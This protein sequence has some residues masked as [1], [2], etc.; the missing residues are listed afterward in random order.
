MFSIKKCLLFSLI[1]FLTINCVAAQENITENLMS[2]NSVYYVSNDGNDLNDGLSINSSFQ[3]IQKALDS[4]NSG[5]TIYLSEGVYKGINN[6]N[7]T[8]DS[9]INII[10]VSPD[11][12]IIDGESINTVFT[13]SEN[14]NVVLKNLSIINARGSFNSYYLP[15][16]ANPS[17]TF[18]EMCGSFTGGAIYNNG[19]L[20][21]ENCIFENN[22][23]WN[24]S[25]E[26]PANAFSKCYGGAIFNNNTLYVYDSVFTN[27]HAGS[28]HQ[29]QAQGGAIFTTGAMQINN[30][31]FDSNTLYANMLRVS[32]QD[33]YAYQ[34][35]AA[36]SGITDFVELNNC[37][38]KNH[39]LDVFEEYMTTKYFAERNYNFD[40]GS[41][42]GAVYY[43]GDNWK[44]NN[45]SF[46]NNSADWGGAVSFRG[47]NIEFDGCSFSNNSASAGCGIFLMDYDL[48]QQYGYIYDGNK[49]DYSNILI[50]NTEFLDNF[51]KSYIYDQRIGTM[52]IGASSCFIKADNVKI[53]NSVFHDRSVLK[54]L[55]FIVPDPKSFWLPTQNIKYSG[56]LVHI[57]GK[58]SLISNSVFEEGYSPLGGAIQDYGFDKKI[59]NC[60]FLDNYAY[61]GGAI[62]HSMGD[63]SVENCNFINNAAYNHG[64]SVYSI[65]SYSARDYSQLIS[66]YVNSSFINGNASYGGAIF[67]TGDNI[68]F[69]D[70]IFINHTAMYGGAIYVLGFN[71]QIYGSDFINATAV[72]KDYSDGGAIYISGDNFLF[73][74]CE[75]INASCGNMGGSIY[76]ISNNI[77]GYNS[78]FI[79]SSAFKGGSIYISGNKGRIQ[80][81]NFKNT[82]ATL[83]GCIYNMADEIIISY[84]NIDST[85]AE[86]AAGAIY[87]EGN[88]IVLYGNNITNSKAGTL[89]NCTYT[90]AS[91]SYLVVSF[92]NNETVEIEKN[93]RKSISAD[94][95]DNLGNPITG[96]YITFILIDSNGD[97]LV[98]GEYEVI[99]GKA[100]VTLGDELELGAYTITGIYSYACD[101]IL[102]K[103]GSVFSYLPSKMALTLTST[104]DAVSLGSVLD[105]FI[106][107]IDSENNNIANANIS[108]YENGVLKKYLVT[109]DAGYVNSSLSEFF[110]FGD[111]NYKFIYEGDLIHGRSVVDL[112]FTIEYVKESV[113]KDV[114]FISTYP[115]W[116]AP[117]N[118]EIPF[119]FFIFDENDQALND[120][121]TKRYFSIYENGVQIEGK[122]SYDNL[123]IVYGTDLLYYQDMIY[124]ELI[125]FY[126]VSEYGSFFMPISKEIPGVYAYTIEFKGGLVLTALPKHVYQNQF[127]EADRIYSPKN[128]SFILIV[129]HENATKESGIFASG[130]LEINEVTFPT[131]KIRLS[132]NNTF[133]A[134]K[135]VN[136]YDN[137]VYLGSVISD[138]KGFASFTVQDYL[139]VGEHLFEFIYAGDEEYLASIEFINATVYT[140]PNK[141]VTFFN[142]T[143]SLSVH[144]MGNNF[145][146]ILFDA[147]GN[148]FNDTNITVYIAGNKINKKYDLTTDENG[149]FTIPL[150]VGA[151]TIYIRC[152]YEGNRFFKRNSTVF[153]V[154]VDSIKSSLYGVSSLEVIGQDNYLSLVLVDENF[155]PLVNSTI[156]ISFYSNEYNITYYA[157]TND[158]G[159]ARLKINL[160]VGNY[161]ALSAFDGDLWHAN[162][163]TLTKVDVYGDYSNLT[164][165]ENL[166]L[167]EK[168]NYYTVKLTDSKGNP[169]SN[170][171]VLITINNVSY[172]RVTDKNGDA[173]LKINLNYGYYNVTT[174]YKGSL[175]YKGSSIVSNLYMVTQDFKLPSVLH[176][177]DTITYRGGNNS[178]NVT[179]SDIYGNP[180]TNEHITFFIK[181]KSY[182]TLTDENGV[183]TLDFNLS[184]GNYIVMSIYDGTSKYQANNASTRVKIVNVDANTTRFV[185]PLYSI[186]KGK[187]NVFSQQ[188]I[189]SKDQPV[190]GEKVTLTVNG[191][192]YERITDENGYIYLNI[193]LNP[194]SYSINSL[195]EGSVNY[196][197][198]QSISEIVVI[199][200]PTLKNA[201]LIGETNVSFIGK[202]KYSVRLVDEDDNPVGG[203]N[204]SFRINDVIYNRI[205]DNEGYASLNLNLNPGVYEMIVALLNSADYRD[206]N[207]KAYINISSTIHGNNLI[208][209]YRNA[210]QFYAYISDVDGNPL[211]NQSVGMNINGVFYYR[212]TDSEGKVKLNINLNPG[213]YILTVIDPNIGLMESYNV[214]VLS[215]L[216]VHDLLKVYKNESQYEIKLLDDAGNPVANALVEININGVYYYRMTNEKGIAVLNINLE[217][218]KYIATVRDMNNGL[219]MSSDVVVV[220]SPLSIKPVSTRI[221]KGD[222]LQILI[223]EEN[224][225]VW[226]HEK[227]ELIYNDVSYSGY[228]ANDGIISFKMNFNSG[229]YIVGYK[230][231]LTNTGGN[232]TI[233]VV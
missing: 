60:T 87:N 173:R 136:V 106:V 102:T 200:N 164:T 56:G 8:I 199:R 148:L 23:V 169:L 77:Y 50:N 17:D 141:T 133:L 190:V 157:F 216:I 206:T 180:L 214:T 143:T 9:D 162:S 194:G 76:A 65:Y 223:K 171:N 219:L 108:V 224:G 51:M 125:T 124:G 57:S 49:N 33:L 41:A 189:D 99:E 97:E 186:Y 168:G 179:L 228:T 109:D 218:G 16:Y 3:S 110:S 12:T 46:L 54:D 119:E 40:Y 20:T 195:Y 232:I 36:I 231:Y 198:T 121:S 211:V 177:Y 11:E 4:S 217:R 85:N 226:P 24:I 70:L 233:N 22:T 170:E 10:G 227:V 160:P 135:T 138:S 104:Y 28:I 174:T 94:V 156:T 69:K 142:N 139:D 21:I 107:L 131:Y 5:T 163:T 122:R 78:T 27:N 52:Y 178:F 205:T 14:S 93:K 187:D 47:S 128:V 183:A 175:G 32:S 38:F 182:N 149:T 152:T 185:S 116:I 96:G 30:T 31:V 212:L 79:N 67:D 88:K 193:N 213:S 120:V 147:D 29:N 208:K 80:S 201:K 91:I 83:G 207:L 103:T 130:P 81:N 115:Y 63:I 53:D 172:S 86:V 229:E 154:S 127:P 118:N 55:E 188:L 105:Y 230:E 222:Y 126:K 225:E 153:N 191:V 144:G 101:P 37:I 166:V 74:D 165:I 68:L 25:G 44:F 7:L 58:S 145:T 100:Y 113:Y 82:N 202:G 158:S 84:N 137:G 146:G 13:V 111:Y 1:L 45:C 66:K 73:E 71:K 184:L 132:G 181:S 18:L 89:A 134:N 72:G 43:D 42:G 117:I 35:G 39:H 62:Y 19:I 92:A 114:N 221:S 196:F 112:N 204:L 155:Y 61:E 129:N 95:T 59:I 2:E 15:Y 140:N 203:E 159:V 210:S 176:A 150:D 64:G 26:Y 209:Y 123:G 98:L 192:D 75:F 167:R 197:S 215:T 220:N 151:G 34:R 6:V 90:E 48:N 161:Y